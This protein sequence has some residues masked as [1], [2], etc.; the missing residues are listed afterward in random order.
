MSITEHRP[1]ARVLDIMQLLA[2]SREGLT[3]TEIATAIGVPKSTITP[4]IRTLSDRH[5]ITPGRNSG[6]Y[7][8]GIT[9]FIVGS[10]C[11]QNLDTLDII[12]DYMK[13]IVKTTSEACQ[14]GIL[15]DGDVLYLAKEDS[16]EPIRLVSFIGK[17]LPAYSTALGKALI[18]EYP[19][20]AL[21][22][23]YHDTLPPVTKNTI[24]D[25][26][27]LYKE[28]AQ[29]K[30]NGYA[31]EHE[32]VSKNINCFAVPLRKSGKVIA[33]LSVSLPTFRLTK[34]KEKKIIAALTETRVKLEQIFMDLSSDELDF[35]ALLPH[36]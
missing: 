30:A 29:V 13:E 21:K 3:L 28:L 4:I 18:C 36:S 15:I 14:L 17:R 35:T 33:A 5:F 2:T 10:A 22:Q 11:L 6:Q 12:K 8:I 1:T 9:A 34:A 7:V 27:I 20:D 32:E 19:L 23:L 24:T 26:A 31:S 25:F 16:P